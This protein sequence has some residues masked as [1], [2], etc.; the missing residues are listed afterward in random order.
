[1]K[2]YPSNS[3][4]AMARIL[5]MQMMCDGNFDPAEID[6]LEHKRVYEALGISRKAF[7]QVFQDYCN[8]VSDD[9]SEDGNIRL[10]DRERID[11]MLDAVDEP[12]K[13]LMLAAIALG[14]AKADNDFSNVEL[15]VF[16]HMLKYWRLNLEDLQT[17]FAV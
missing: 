11:Q 4:E 17:A 7:I 13:R 10:V 6:E 3:A 5:V 2:K 15:A 14:I 9:A 12:R 8:D 16:R 1:M